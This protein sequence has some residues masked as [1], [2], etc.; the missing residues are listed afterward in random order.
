[1]TNCR[2]IN[3]GNQ[4]DHSAGLFGFLA[5]GMQLIAGPLSKQDKSCSGWFLYQPYSVTGLQHSLS[6]DITLLHV[7]VISRSNYFKRTL[8][9]AAKKAQQLPPACAEYSRAITMKFGWRFFDT[10]CCFTVHKLL[11]GVLMEFKVLVL[12]FKAL[13]RVGHTLLLEF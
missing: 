12:M 2:Q 13:N 10:S 1:M 3:V 11:V 5:E 6:F 4:K 9:Y 8:N 7:F